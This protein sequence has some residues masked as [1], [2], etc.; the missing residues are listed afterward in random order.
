MRASSGKGKGVR[1]TVLVLL[2]SAKSSELPEVISNRRVLARSV[3][4]LKFSCVSCFKTGQWESKTI[5]CLTGWFLS[6]HHLT[7]RPPDVNFETSLSRKVDIW[8]LGCQLRLVLTGSS[9]FSPEPQDDTDH[10]ARNTQLTGE[11]LRRSGIKGL[12]SMRRI[13]PSVCFTCQRRGSIVD[14]V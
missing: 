8:M 7:H 12:I 9:L 4:V 6:Y 11:F 1:R 10:L 3:V 2:T 5:A 13:L 14:V